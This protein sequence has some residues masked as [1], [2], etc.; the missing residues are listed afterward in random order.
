MDIL[1]Y[2]RFFAFNTYCYLILFVLWRYPKSKINRICA[3]FLTSCAVWIFTDFFVL[4]NSNSKEI[5]VLFSN[6]GSIGWISF[7]SFFLWFTLVFSEKKKI[8]KSK[9]IFPF[10][11][12]PPILLIYMQWKGFLTIRFKGPFGWGH[13]WSNSIWAYLF[14]L[15]YLSF[16]IGAIYLLINFKKNTK[17]LIRKKQVKI[18]LI[19]ILIPLFVGSVTDV[20]LP[21]L[22]ILLFPPC[23]NLLILIW[24]AG[25]V[26]A[27]NRYKLMVITPALAAE[28]IISTMADPLILLD[29]TGNIVTANKATL[30]LSGC[31]E[32]ELLRK[33]IEILFEE[34]NFK[35]TLLNNALK[36][37]DVKNFEIDFKT[38]GGNNIPVIFSSSSILDKTE[39]IAGIVCIVKDISVR[40]MAEEKLKKQNE[41]IQQQSEELRINSA[42]LQ[43]TNV[44]LEERQQQIEEQSEEL[45]AQR[46]QLSLLN[47]TKDKLF[48]ILGHD[49]RSPFSTLIGYS[50]L[51]IK[52][53]RKYPIE[54]IEHQLNYILESSRQTFYMLNNLLEWSR[55]QREIIGFNPEP[56]NLPHYL[57]SE[58]QILKQQASQKNL[59]IKEEIIG[60]EKIIN[61]DPNLISTVIRNLISN[62]I[63]YSFK[64]KSIHITLCYNENDFLFSVKD[65]G[66]GIKPEVKENLFKISNIGSTVGTMGERGTGLGLLI[67]GDFIAKHNGKIWVESELNM[68]SKFCFTIPY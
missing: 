31:R 64:D 9:Y 13:I 41:K 47:T 37:E 65:E 5:A 45:M 14:F 49:L 32:N 58:L 24:A 61:A 60:T 67:C 6:I 34:K 10:L 46:D 27:I 62:A 54:K 29:K 35:S 15:Y 8:L 28:N 57:S 56:I 25:L 63:K 7:S 22:D 23:F 39:D 21:K 16:M 12:I 38:K 36:G 30:D 51:L 11:F 33:S 2:L 43:E 19:T 68:G 53:L 50:Q 3:A 20:L 26:Y 44:L 59:Q 55:S 1:L 66:T 4:N 40:K 48:S 18:I 17:E 52:N 42:V